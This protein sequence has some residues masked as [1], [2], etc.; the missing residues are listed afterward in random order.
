MRFVFIYKF[1]IEKFF[2]DSIFNFFIALGSLRL[3]RFL[4]L[5]FDK[6][7]LEIFGPAGCYFIL[8]QL[9]GNLM[10]LY[11]QEK[12][13]LQFFYFLVVSVIFLNIFFLFIM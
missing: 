10:L 7:I 6:G 1:F 3:S 8:K 13:S 5:A 4:F 2:F 11:K 12:W 9:S